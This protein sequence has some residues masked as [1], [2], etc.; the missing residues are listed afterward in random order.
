MPSKSHTRRTAT[1]P[2]AL[3]A[4]VTANATAAGAPAVESNGHAP[5]R[6]DFAS[7][8]VEEAEPIKHQRQREH[9]PFTDV[10]RRSYDESKTLA[11]VV[12]ADLAKR[13]VGMVR[14][15]AADANLGVA[16]QVT[17]AGTGQSR[18]SFQARAKRGYNRKSK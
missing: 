13:T 12:P 7:L 16:T 14:R 1:R 17:Y 6:F 3:D 15:A 11:V 9:N 4:E 10:V 18:V 2:N 5:Q 8:T